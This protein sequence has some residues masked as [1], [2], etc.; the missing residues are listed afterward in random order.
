M[1]E[2]NKKPLP[3]IVVKRTVQHK[4]TENEVAKL[5]VD[6]R[7]A[8]AELK[9]KESAA[10]AAANTHKALVTEAGSRMDTLN[11]LLQA[12][13]ED[14]LKECI[15]VFRPAAKKKDFYAILA[16]ET[17]DDAANRLMKTGEKPVL[18]EDMAPEDF[19][20]D[21]F[22]AE[23]AFDDKAELVLWNVEAD[24]GAIIIGKQ[25]GK[26]FT[27]L[28]CSI[29][30]KSVIERLDAEQPCSKLRFDAIK[31]AGKRCCDWL[32]ETLDKDVAAGFKAKIEEV[33]EANKELVE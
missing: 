24:K 23:S 10:K 7:Q 2:K 21:L 1:N 20:Q 31:R 13:V 30:N 5:N 15:V 4:F 17:A 19:E 11:A 14:R 22:R 12:G 18:T 8:Y 28:R 32:A 16:D 9:S 29:G 27:A 3:P 26:W 25:N 6:F 33:V